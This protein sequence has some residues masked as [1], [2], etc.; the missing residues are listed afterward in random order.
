MNP[1]TVCR[2]QPMVFTISEIV[3]P[4]FRCSMA[5]TWA[6]LLPSRGV[7][8]S[9]PLAAV[10]P[11]GVALAAVAFL[12][13]LVLAGA[14]LA[15]RARPLALCAAFGAVAGSGFA[16][17]PSPRSWMRAPIRLMA[18]WWHAGGGAG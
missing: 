16:A 4:P 10:L 17:S 13:A 7:A 1:R 12:A 3:A 11:L 2:C 5:T 9:R 6:V 8:A 15:A 14:P 18:A